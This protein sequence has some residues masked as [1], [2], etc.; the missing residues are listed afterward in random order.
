MAALVNVSDCPVVPPRM[1]KMFT[2]LLFDCRLALAVLLPSMKSSNVVGAPR[3]PVI[4]PVLPPVEF[5]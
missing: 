2:L 5:S 3:G 1:D 4:L